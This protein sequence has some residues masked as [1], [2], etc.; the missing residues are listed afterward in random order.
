[1]RWFRKKPRKVIFNPA[2]ATA[3]DALVE[4][5]NED[6]GALKLVGDIMERSGN[7]NIERLNSLLEQEK[8]AHAE[9]SQRFRALAHSYDDTEQRVQWLLGG[10]IPDSL[11]VEIETIVETETS[12]GEF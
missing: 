5:A 11:R 3:G 8:R 12:R 9:T 2:A 4:I 7:E 1:M 6:K 10:P